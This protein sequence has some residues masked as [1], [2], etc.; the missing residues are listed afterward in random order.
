MVTPGPVSPNLRRMTVSVQVPVASAWPWLATVQVTSI[1][2]PSGATS[3][4]EML[5]T[6]RSGAGDS[7]TWNGPETKRLLPVWM[8]SK[9]PPVSSTRY[10]VP[11]TPFG[12]TTLPV[13]VYW[14]SGARK[15]R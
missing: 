13:R 12:S 14:P 9:G 2:E 4:A 5:L 15:P 7:A 1:A 3:G 10:C 11:D 8:N 6:T